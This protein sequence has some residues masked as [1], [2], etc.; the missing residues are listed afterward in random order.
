MA[1]KH[2]TLDSLVTRQNAAEKAML[3]EF[4]AGSVCAVNISFSN[5]F[6]RLA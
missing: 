5:N 1:I 3:E 4:E 2:V 6:I